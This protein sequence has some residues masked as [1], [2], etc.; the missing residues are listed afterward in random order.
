MTVRTEVPNVAP[1]GASMRYSRAVRIGPLIEVSGTTA[2]DA[3]GQVVAVGDV[4]GQVRRCFEIVEEAL[5]EL[6]A[7]LSDVIR[8]RLYVTDTSTWKDAGAAHDEVFEGWPA[9]ASSAVGIASLIH[10]DLLVEVEVTAYLPE[11]TS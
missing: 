9:P 8:T 5:E 6:G 2:V 1:W 10:P 4:A 7:S 11:S 3:A